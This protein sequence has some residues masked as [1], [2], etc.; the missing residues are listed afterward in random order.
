MNP[1]REELLFGLVLTKPAAE[2][3]AWL[4]REC[5]DDKTLR[6]R[7]DAL[8]AAHEQTNGVLTD[9]PVPFGVP[10]SGGPP[11]PPAKAGTPSAPA[12]KATIKL[13]PAAEPPYE[14]AGQT[15]GRYKSLERVGEA[16]CGV[17]YMAD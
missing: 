13:D 2:R 16:S 10:P 9:G 15:L 14:A 7:L 3:I 4:D 12:S 5:G 1:T 11:L 6:T 8:L 17:V